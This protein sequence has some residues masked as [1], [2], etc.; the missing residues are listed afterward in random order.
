MPNIDIRRAT[1]AYARNLHRR[2]VCEGSSC[3]NAIREKRSVEAGAAAGSAPASHTTVYVSVDGRLVGSISV[4]DK[5]RDNAADV[6][7]SLQRRGL[8][9]LLVSG[10][11]LGPAHEVA[12]AVG[13][14]EADVHAGV[15]PGGKA[16]LVEREQGRGARV[17]MVGDGINDTGEDGFPSKRN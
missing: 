1:R 14:H 11:A 13:I 15:T 8:R 7:A 5:I 2:F 16:E 6:V 3:E 9:V 4:E 12:R 17:A 10:D